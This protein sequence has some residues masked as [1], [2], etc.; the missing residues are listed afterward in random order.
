METQPL[1][2]PNSSF[3]DHLQLTSV[4]VQFADAKNFYETP[5]IARGLPR[6]HGAFALH[7]D[8]QTFFL[9]KTRLYLTSKTDILLETLMALH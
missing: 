8:W 4:I 2:G 5:H 7:H 1:Q 6:L 9:L 3:N